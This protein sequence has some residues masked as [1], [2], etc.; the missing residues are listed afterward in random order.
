ML[1]RPPLQKA[2]VWSVGHRTH[3]RLGKPI[4]D[5]II[6]H[7]GEGLL[8]EDARSTIYNFPWDDYSATTDTL[9]LTASS[10]TEHNY[11]K[12]RNDGI[13]DS[14]DYDY[15]GEQ[16]V[17]NYSST[18]HEAAPVTIPFGSE[19]IIGMGICAIGLIIIVRK[20]ILVR[21]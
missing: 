17:C 21:K 5:R 7:L 14:W 10:G 1:L 13:V 9:N 3:R 18:G 11:V 15:N 2:L 8:F 20:K 16:I 19:F 4:M 12:L 6:R